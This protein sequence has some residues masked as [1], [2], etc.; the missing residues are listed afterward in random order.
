MAD[1]PRSRASHQ[2]FRQ[3]P[4]ATEGARP[5]PEDAAATM[6]AG[7]VLPWRRGRTPPQGREEQRRETLSGAAGRAGARCRTVSRPPQGRSRAGRP[8]GAPQEAAPHRDDAVAGTGTGAPQGC[9]PCE[10]VGMATTEASAPPCVAECGAGPASAVGAV[11]HRRAMEDEESR[12][13]VPPEA[14]PRRGGRVRAC[15]A[16]GRRQAAP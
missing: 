15:H 2:R 7:V 11:G 8:T 3:D 12:M 5:A 14:R 4:V 9:M 1:V 16:G 13:T 10:A 6:R